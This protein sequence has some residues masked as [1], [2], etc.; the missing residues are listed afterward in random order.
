MNYIIQKTSEL[1]VDCILPFSS[2]RTVVRLSKDRLTNKIK[3][4][5]EIAQSST[6]Q[7]D[8]N[9]PAEIRSVVTF[10]KLMEILN[11][12]DALKMILWEEEGVS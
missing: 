7:S 10:K 5:R 1:G 2:K 12:E 4:W 8:R 3:H 6:K 11:G 9:T